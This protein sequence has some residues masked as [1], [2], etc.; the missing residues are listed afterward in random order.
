MTGVEEYL[1]RW[2]KRG[3]FLTVLRSCLGIGNGGF[4]SKYIYLGNGRKILGRKDDVSSSLIDP[5]FITAG[6]WSLHMA[7]DQKGG[8]L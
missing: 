2:L 6:G 3:Q 4:D 5:K 1:E 8:V 7:R